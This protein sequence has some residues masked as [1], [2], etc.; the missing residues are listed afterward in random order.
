MT[1]Q[2]QGRFCGSCQKM[3]IDFSV[4]SD[5]EI[6]DYMSS[7]STQVC[8]RFANDQLKREISATENKRRFSWAYIWNV[9]LATFLVTESYAQGEPA[10]K[11]KPVTTNKPVLPDT[12]PMMGSITVIEPDQLVLRKE[13]SGVV[14]DG[15][16]QP[17]QNASIFIKGTTIGTT[18]DSAGNFHLQV[19]NDDSIALVISYVGFVSKT[20][21]LDSTTDWQHIKVVMNELHEEVTSGVIIV[22]YKVPKKEKVKRT[23]NNWVPAALKKEVKIYPNPVVRGN[24]IQANVSLKQPGLYKLELLDVQGRVVEVQK[25]ELNSKEK[26][27]TIPTQTSWSTGIYWLRI[28][29]SG[30]KNVYQAK[31]L[32]K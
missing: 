19:D 3:V 13:I 2:E 12:S 10:M 15:N 30:V 31:L 20:V 6:L 18:S 21:L 25:L 17:L 1:P 5:K 27:V 14:I 24:A 23:I 8:G 16:Q 26:Q 29:A 4:M 22:G 9:I 28:T 7:A 11:K 32:L